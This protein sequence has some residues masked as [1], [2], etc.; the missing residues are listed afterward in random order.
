MCVVWVD[1]SGFFEPIVVK[2]AE[3][4][5]DTHV[6]LREDKQEETMASAQSCGG[7][8]AH[9]RVTLRNERVDGKEGWL[10]NNWFDRNSLHSS[11]HC[12]GDDGHSGCDGY[13]YFCWGCCYYVNFLFSL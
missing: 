13:R 7:E 1:E 2:V 11:V 6:N 3:A 10:P 9:E 5:C 8:V 12:V 4:N